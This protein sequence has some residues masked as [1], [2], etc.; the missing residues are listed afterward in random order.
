[1][2]DET[3]HDIMRATY[4]ALCRHGYANL[5]MQDIADESGKSKASLHYH[6]DSKH[7][8]LAAFLDYLFEWFTE[9]ME[10]ALADVDDPVDRLVVVIETALAPPDDEETPH[11]E[12]QTALLEIK[13]QA[14]YDDAFRARLVEF[15]HF[16]RDRIHAVIQDG[17]ERGTFR[18]DVDPG[19]AAEFIVSATTGARTR[20]VA[21][22]HRI[23]RTRRS[24]ETYI[25]TWLLADD[26]EA[27][28][29]G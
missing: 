12:F 29:L 16:L 13:A 27:V 24:L 1:M 7:D 5:T 26:A 18:E 9:R 10:T 28:R 14:P 21:V 4:D 23:D 3:K 20:H 17:I 8:L 22:E 19:D 6:Y 2:T 15:D 11:S 25:G